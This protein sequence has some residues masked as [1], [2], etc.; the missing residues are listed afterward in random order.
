MSAP[1]KSTNSPDEDEDVWNL[2]LPPIALPSTSK[3]PTEKQKKLMKYRR[4][5]EQ[6]KLLNKIIINIA[7][8]D[9]A[10]SMEEFVNR[11]PEPVAPQLPYTM[12]SEQKQIRNNYL[13]MKKCVESNPVV[14]I[15]QEWLISMLTLVPQSLME[16]KD[17]EKLVEELL[18]EI[19]NDYEMS[20][21]RYMVRSV[22]V[23]PEVKLLEYEKEGPLPVEP[24]G[25]DFSRPWHKSFIQARKQIFENLHILHPTLRILL[26]IGYRMFSKL[27]IVD[28]SGFRSR[29]PIECESLQND[30]SIKCLKTE[31]KILNTWY[32][33]VINLFTRKEALE[34]VKPDQMDSF[35]NCVSTLM[36]NQLK[37]LLK[38]TIEAYVKLFDLEDQR[39][40]PLFRMELTFDDEKMDFYPSFPDLEDTILCII[41]LISQ[42][43]QNVQT[44]HSWLGGTN[45]VTTIDTELPDHVIAWAS[46]VL[47]RAI[48]ENLKGAKAH[49]NS[50]VEKYGWLVDGAA[51]DRITKF[52]AEEHSFDEYAELID[53][54]L[55]LST[56]IMSLPM[57]AHFPMVRLDCDD[58]KQG[59]CE[60]AKSFAYKLLDLLACNH[61]EENNMICNEFET[62]KERALKVPE[63][64]EEMMESIAFIDKAK[65]I[66]IQKL[67][68]RIKEC[69]RR[70]NYLLDIYLFEP[71]D[72]TLNATVL[73]WPQNINPIFDEND[74]II[75]MSKRKGENELLAKR[76]KLIM[77]VEKQIRR[78][79]EFTEYCD[80]DRM[81]QYVT[82]MRTLQKRIQDADEAVT[83]INK[84][85]KLLNWELTEYPELETLKVNTEP[86]QKLFVFILKWQR[87]EKRW[88]DGS[89]LDLNGEKME[90][91]VDEF[92]RDI[93]KTLR[94]FQQQLKKAEIE[95]KKS[96]RRAVV[97]ER[98]EEE[99]K[100]SPTISMCNAV[101]QQIKDFKE[102]I[103]LV[104]ILCN[105]GIKARHWNQMS[106]IVGYDLTP[107]S[108]TTLRKVLKQ[109]LTPYL[110]QFE[111]ISMGASKE[112]SL[113]K[114]MHN[115]METWDSIFFQ[116]SLYR[117]TGVNILSAVDEIQ[118]I[119][120]DQ[121]VKTQTMRGSPFIK[122]FEKQMKEWE[123]RLIRIQDTIDEWLKVQA[124][125]LYLE[126]IFSSEDI[127]QQMPEEGRQFQTVDRY[128]R[129]IMKYCVKDPKVLAATSLTGL[130]EKLQ[131]CNDLLDKI[132]K[133]LNAYLEKKRLFFPR[134]FFLSNDEMLEILSETKDPLRVQPHLKK[135]FEGIAKLE[136]RPNLDIKAMYSTEGER[137]EFIS[138]IS[139][140]EA[141]GA[142]EKWLIQVEDIMLRSIHDV[143]TRSRLAYP[144]SPRKDWVR[145]WPGQVVLCVSQMFWTSEVHEAIA[146]GP[147]GL[148][149]YY[150]AL[151]HQ[152]NDIV[153]LVRGKLSKQTRT[154]LGALVTIDVH[155][156]DVV[157]EMIESGVLKE[158]DFQWLAQLRYYWEY[159]NV[160]VR[161]INCNVKYA[162]EY[163]GNSPRLVITPLTDRCYRTLIGAFYLNLGG[164]PEGPAG[165]GKTE[166]T[167]DLAKAV[168]VQC[169]VFNCS[170]GLDYLAMGKFFKGLA[171]S[172]AWACFDEFNRIEL[173]VLSV[174]AQQILC[175]Q[176]AIQQ[177]LEIFNFEGTEL[178]LNPNCF[179]A[180]TMNPGYAGRSELP[181]NLKVLFRTVA[182]M[183]PNYALIAEISLY[184][185]GFLNAKPLS[186][187]IVM[188]Y[189]LCS[190]QLSSQFHYDYG[191]RAVK[192]VLIAAGNLK[193]KFPTE[194]ED[195]LL[196]RSIK[197]VNEPKFLSHDIPLFMGITSD[198]FPGIKLPEADYSDFL[199]CANE[200]C[201]EHN[202]QPVKVFL[203]KMI[204]TY[205]MMIVRHGFMLVGEPFS[206]K[207]KVL[208]VLADTLTLM[209][210]REYGEEEKVIHRTV[211]P[212]AITMGQLFGRFDPVSHEWTDGI[213]ANT[214]REFALTETPDRK[215]VVFDG[216]IDTL[217]IESMNTVLDDNKKLCLMSG[218][219]IQMSPQ[220]SLIFEAMDLSQASP[221]TVSRCGMI[222][223]EPS[224]LG[225][226]PLV[227]SW[228]ST[229]PE[230]LD[231]KEF[232]DLFEELFDWL[233]P[234]ALRVRRK[235]CK[236]LVPTS[237]INNV[238]S[239]TRLLEI[240]LCHKAKKDPSNK[241]IHKWV[242]GCFAFAMIW[243]IGATCDSD[244]RIIFDNFMR[245]IV[246]GKL[247]EHPIPA[248]IGKWEHPFEEKGLVYDYMFELKGKGRW[249]HWNEAVKNIN[250]SDKSI[251]VQ[252][253]IVPTMDT[254]RYTYLMELCIKYGKPLLFVGPTGTGKS[255]Y[256]KDKLMHHLQK[257]LY[258]PFFL[259][260]S[261][262]TSANQTQNIIM[263]RLDK[264]RKGI[265]GPPLGKKCVI[266]VDDMNMPALE[267]YGA[268]PPVELLRQFF[269][270]GIW[271]DLKDTNKITLVDIQL[272]AAMGP[273]GGGRNPV[274]PR[275]LRHF[276]ICTINSFSDETMV[277]IFSTVVSFYLRVNEFIPEYF[278]I[279]NQIVSGTMEVYKKAMANLLPTPAK[280][281]YTFNLRDF[282]RVILGC[283]LIKKDS[284]VNKHTM[285]RLFVHEVF[286]VF[287][288]RLV[289]DADR[290][291]LFKLMK[292]IVKEHFKEA[293]DAVFSHLRQGNAPISEEDMRNLLFGDYMNPDLEGDER[294]YYE[295]P[296]I[297]MFNDVVDLCLDEYN[298][299]HK[300][301]MNLVIFRYVLEHLSRIC[302]VLK[303][304]GGNA[305][306][307]GM[308][309]SGRQ[310]LTRLATSMA[311]MNIF[312]PEI[313]KSYGMN[314][315]REDLKNLL[316]NAGMKGL[317]TVFLITDTQIKE[318]GFLE[319][320]DSVL[321]TGEVPNLFAADEK[322]EVMEGV[323]AVAQAGH[324]HEEL[325]PLALFAFFVNRCKDNLHVVVAFS[326]IG[327]AFRNRL[328][329]FPSLINCCTIDW[330]QPWPEDALERV[331][332]KFLEKLELTENERQEVVPIC[333][334]FHTSVLSLSERFLNELGRHNYVTPTSYLELI[335]SF[336]LLLTQ[337]RDT[338]MKAKKRYTNGLDKLAF[339]ESQVGEMKKELVNLQPKLEQAKVDN[340]AMMKIIEKESAEVEAKSKT[341]KVDEELATEKAAEAQALKNECE[342]DLAEAIPA[343]EAALAALDTLKPADITIVKSMKNPPSGVKLV[344][345]AICV[346]KDIKP[347]KIADP[348]GIGGKI[349][350]Y[351]G[352]SKK[353]LGEMN[354]LKDLREYDKDNIPVSVMQK[355]RSEYLTNPEF[356]PPKVAK[357]SSAAEGLCKWIMAMEVYDR[358]AKVVAPK[359]ARLAEAQQSLAHTMALL[360]QKRAELK[361]V[362]DRLEA[363]QETFVEKTEEKARLEFQVDLCAKKLE[364]AEK[365]I[366]GL[367]GEKSRWSHAADDLQ[368]TYDNLTGDVLVSAGVIAYL[369]AFTAGFRQECTKEWSKLCQVKNIPC[370]ESF[371]LSKTLGDPIKIRAW[372]IAGLPTDQF[373]ID[374]GVIVDNSRRWPLMID[375]QGQANKWIKHSEK[376]NRLSVIKFTDSDYM[377]TLENCIQFG[378]PLLLE[379]V[380]EEIDPSLEP[381][382]LRQTFKQVT[383]EGGMDCIRLGETI[384]EYSFD[385]KFY[386]T[387]KLRNPHYLP[388]LATKVSLLNFMITPEGLEDQ[389]LGI[390]VAKERPEL[391]EERNALI[392]QSAA[393]K[394]QLKDIENKILETLQSSEGNIL[395]D[396]SAITILDSAKIM[397]NEITKK[398]Q[399][400]E[401]TEIKIAQSREGYRP[402][403]KHSS[404]LFF[405]IAD[406][407]NIDPMYQYSLS[408][409]V[410]LYINS[411]HDSNK[412]KI[413]EKRLRYLNDHF[414]YNLYCNVCRSLFE[415]DKLLFSF[416]LCCNL[417]MARKE[418]EHQEFMFLLTGGVGLKSKFKNPDPS[419]LQDKSWDEICRASDMSAFKGLRNHVTSQPNEWRN[420]YDSKEPQNVPLPTP[421]NTDLNEIK[422]MIILRCLRPDKITPAIT[423]F[424]TD[425]LGKK[426]VEPPP[427]DLTKSYLDSNSSIPLIF[428][429]SP[430]ADPMASLLKFANDKNMIGSKFQ[431][432]SLG[433]G[434]G[435][436]A[437]KMIREGMEE[438]TWI[439]LQ[440]CHLAVSWMPMLE[441][442]C[443]EFNS[444]TCHSSFRLWLTSYPSPKFPV[445]ILQNGV[446]MTNEPP[447]G[448]RLNLLQSF[449]SDP[450]SDPDFFAG[451][452]GKEQRWEK[453]LFGVCFFHALVQERKKFGPLGW[454][455]PYGFNESDL[456][457]SV[458]QLQLFI[459]EYEHIPF[460]AITYLT[461]ECNYGGRVTDDWDRRLLLTMLADFYNSDI[462]ENSH[463]KFSPSGNYYAPS[464]GTYDDY[465]E[466][467]KNLPVSQQP[468]VFGLHDN[469]DISKDLQQ[470]KIT[471]ESLL[472]TQGGTN[473][474]GSKS[475][476]DSTLYEIADDILS[477]L[478]NDYDIEAALI[479][480]PVRYEESMNTVLVQEME[481]FNNLI[482]TIRTT[483]VNLKKAIKGLVVMDSELEALC[484]SLLIGKVAEN[485]AKR[486][487]PSLKPL[488]SYILDF[489]ARLKFLQDWYDSGKPCVFWLSGF[490]FTQAFLTGGMQNYARKYTI[491]I[492]LLGYEFQ[493]IPRDTSNTAPEDGVYING[494]FLDGA[495]WDRAKGLLGEQHP[496]ILFDTMPII[497]I[498][499]AKKSEIKKSNAYVCPLYKTSERKGVLSTTGHSTNFV[500]AMKLLT[501]QPVQH[502]IKRGVALLCQLDD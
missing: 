344:M 377:R 9:Y 118:T 181:D 378:T 351:W 439:C 353:L 43:L 264:R 40:L 474:G 176:R 494:L 319:D 268:Q 405:S 34:G 477:K 470:T 62:I 211:N 255:V 287:Y 102:N 203:E 492:D 20:M 450:L 486:S 96:L 242:T 346:M 213:V 245:D 499:P 159:D 167:K 153:E 139:T 244:G 432:I 250:Y 431:S 161:I 205:E 311:K 66:G 400:A 76:E 110:E 39:W 220:M 495:R 265:Y 350:D 356:D 342:S 56:E 448:L 150:Q 129:D 120:D 17:R 326:P 481:R 292:E 252:D 149:N 322:Q 316:R 339:A 409:F 170:D 498:K 97:E 61:R 414:T 52:I 93:Y 10:M 349:L 365:L 219:I 42:T 347:E 376:E 429:L 183:V 274:T 256:V 497:W 201:K 195:I 228:L 359:K 232:Q 155:A 451:C 125:W 290:A 489:L 105:P 314:E 465:I 410:N 374:N 21:K 396:E 317:K 234:P 300:T 156:R 461:G 46:S 26:E 421:W 50:Y 174:V 463:Y 196:L 41:T 206:G 173:E 13:F 476:G 479:K 331:A 188:T 257:D 296:S 7:T 187:K 253:V 19:T 92:F 484:A 362:E 354:F 380:G 151:Q 87:T 157:M 239:L 222:Y 24:E 99:K 453:L 91:E 277:R 460:E 338:I 407:A 127:M 458:R 399:I 301:R 478:P 251:K 284:V 248:T 323:R 381:L 237:N 57:I 70:M 168:A 32:P 260:F 445:T 113:E 413:L 104:T 31:E 285:I 169:V 83:F 207:T 109:N 164:A 423:T 79:H 182:M 383:D 332:I 288:D 308:G 379:N 401:K 212:K 184:S 146:S 398:Q 364:R 337:N 419:W 447:T 15:Q 341:V 375:P 335:G 131:N 94:F 202:V 487:Y 124:Q 408:W 502:W 14:P 194:N 418:I 69:Q 197:D 367:G 55:N 438:G 172:G 303:Q 392:L 65:T 388:E 271:Y 45:I 259:N 258:F 426:F 327:D 44:I 468:E 200:C 141:R 428:V 4:V 103:P 270:H 261:A 241:N 482:R 25:L 208:H 215:W 163:L 233:V 140:S 279:G 483:L 299:T 33:R 49:F 180:I 318:E 138:T 30:V 462:V 236:E 154:T 472:L 368:N 298:Q 95:R 390:V 115:M 321:N 78:M 475:G 35:Y 391:E 427:F 72:L 304:S 247:D 306:L 282:S 289:D 457:I 249:A 444:E 152:L 88:M 417:L 142:V 309:G 186:V 389:L 424:V 122:P 385:F 402:I 89:F 435:P 130:L 273:P 119:L 360:N 2:Q 59:L 348:S 214:F 22:L 328:R 434:Q 224:Q 108:G 101:M 82:D 112:F 488:G 221:A 267:Q 320:V 386:I 3:E 294:I 227:T 217:W 343:L 416:L 455:I 358:V 313:S 85:E 135:C 254:V 449:V 493:V 134:F 397:S 269:D 420:I 107:D 307:V 128:W 441:K 490:F 165:T 143:I 291:W 136:F 36:S 204:Q 16:G 1:S 185:Y 411:I 443:E 75:E 6:Q 471:F 491:P 496:K 179:V 325:S 193:L 357:A 47:K 329:Q 412:S 11:E 160:R 171:S 230:P 23:K 340:A 18:N 436:I 394:K 5:T 387:T 98:V 336:Q 137:V 395:E 238:V 485:W 74:E 361:A 240:L 192:A 442:I 162:Y 297:Q 305:L 123:E 37:E 8:K 246:I 262:R 266:F 175:I 114:A 63:T 147:E 191:M 243:S 29:G 430:G 177:K 67:Y 68:E 371:S 231:E 229:L 437:T 473:Q 315:W 77:E 366:G 345:A 310:S 144:E 86:Y 73:L 464:R 425:K 216:P 480:Y 71:E 225:W 404:V 235:Q 166:T 384:I 223:L 369:G 226:K 355:I 452:P 446:K 53:E 48:N 372:N 189:R 330:F 501:D 198:L 280:S 334:H 466:F 333:K 12:N 469:V 433:Q 278:T 263:A 121:I 293:F 454:N 145:E 148:K 456:R 382:L 209:N 81:Q 116:T 406:L 106:E 403:A 190:E 467:I 158:T 393:N 324:K 117:E 415:K 54:F 90:G 132:M 500:I 281:H 126:P 363:L 275:F 27:L 64:T 133:G 178:R 199:E 295:I 352:P 60:K 38:R 218:E 28:V 422:K 283:L 302:R 84:E 440:N 276:N 286:R 459:N 100:D 210:Q 80:L 272:M 373:S 111:V 51:D 58:L 370:S 312:Q